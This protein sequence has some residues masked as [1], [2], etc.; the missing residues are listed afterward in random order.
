LGLARCARAGVDDNSQME[1]GAMTPHEL[2]AFL[3][4][5]NDLKSENELDKWRRQ[6][7]EQEEERKHVKELTTGAEMRRWREYFEG[8]VADE[9][10]A[11]LEHVCY[12][13]D[14]MVE[15]A[16]GVLGETR[17]EIEVANKCVID[18]AVADMKKSIEALQQ[19][20]DKQRI[21]IEKL[22]P[23]IALLKRQVKSLE[24]AHNKSIESSVG[25][26]QRRVAS[27][28]DTQHM[29]GETAMAR[30]MARL[31]A[32]EDELRRTVKLDNLPAWIQDGR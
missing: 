21:L 18:V 14:L 17:H 15:A 7:R 27:M 6:E 31:E 19:M 28:E 23:D 2:K 26:L 1:V 12:A 29:T 9:H 3:R 11:M 13:K 22:L 25:Y 5:Q 4:Q 32:A 16:G 8:L 10:A 24:D 20:L 30:L